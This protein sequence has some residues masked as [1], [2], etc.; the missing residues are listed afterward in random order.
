VALALL[1]GDG[2]LRC[3]GQNEVGQLGDGT[4]NDGFTPSVVKGLDHVVEVTCGREH[5]CARRDDGAVY[6]WGGNDKGQLGDG[7]M[8]DSAVPVAVRGL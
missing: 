5:T 1:L 7:S 8:D 2:T 3:W 4:Q 6:S